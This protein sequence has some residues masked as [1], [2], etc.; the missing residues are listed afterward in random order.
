MIAPHVGHL[1]TSVLADVLKRW[2]VLR[3][4]TK[5]HLLTGTDEHG[6]KIQKAADKANK[7]VKLFCDENAAQFKL[8]A[9]RANINYDRFMRTTDEDHKAAVEWFWNELNHRGLIYEAKHE[10]WYCISDETFYPT[11]AV[12]LI[13]RPRD[14]VKVMVSIETGREVEWTEET[15]YHFKMSAFRDQLLQFYEENPD[16][17]VPK[18]RMNEVV[19]GVKEGLKDLSISRPVERLKWGVRVPND[20]SQTIYVWVDALINYLTNTG[21]PSPPNY[22]NRAAWPADIHVVGKDIVKFHGVYWPCLLM[23]LGL[24]LPKQLLTHEH[25]TINNKKM[26]KSDGNFVNPFWA[27]D[28]FGDDIMR[29][30]MIHDGG[31]LDDASYENIWIVQRYKKI[32]Q[33]GLGNLVSRITRGK[34]FSI[35]E[36]VQQAESEGFNRSRRPHSVGPLLKLM[37]EVTTETSILMEEK[38]DPRAAVQLVVRLIAEANRYITETEPFRLVKDPSEQAQKGVRRIIFDCAESIRV[39]AI[40]LQPVMPGKMKRCLDMLGVDEA[41]RSAEYARYGA[42]ATYGTSVVELG[43]AGAAGTLFPPLVAEW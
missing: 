2:H 19:Q 43:K 33:G 21:W 16:F 12:Q 18:V 22:E 26:S 15:N 6:M 25:W 23:A 37:D 24:P 7:D 41:R 30:Y 13:V 14:G 38:L 34:D 39:V 35:R 1:Y 40:L 8:L 27:M 42:D 31:I 4:D 5:A 28:R 11:S 29:F 10:G 9:S 36:S 20:E 3:G 32:L 17:I